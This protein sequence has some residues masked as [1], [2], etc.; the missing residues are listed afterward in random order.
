R[1]SVALREQRAA[2]DRGRGAVTAGGRL[3]APARRGG[4]LRLGALVR[5]DGEPRVGRGLLGRHG[6]RGDGRGRDGRRRRGG[7]RGRGRRRGGRR[8]DRPRGLR[9]D[10]LARRPRSGRRRGGEVRRRDGG[11]RGGCGEAVMVLLGGGGDG[12]RLGF[13]RDDRLRFH[14]RLRL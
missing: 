5:G 7:G 8:L 14:D 9:D 1:S 12:L 2:G 10:V 3:L 13:R 11:E 6:L 4:P